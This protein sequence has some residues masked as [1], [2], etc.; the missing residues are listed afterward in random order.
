MI[1]VPDNAFSCVVIRDSNTIRTYQNAPQQNTTIAYRDYYVN[2][3]YMFVDGEQTFSNY[4][5][6]PSCLNSNQV[7]HNFY[8]RNDLSDILISFFVIVIICF[9]FP[10]KLFGRFFGRWF[11]W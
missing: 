5:I 7:T 2:S 9:Y 10:L 8:Y 1:Y 6:V 11:Q 4:T 3:H